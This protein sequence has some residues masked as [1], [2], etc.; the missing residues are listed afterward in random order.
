MA[1]GN[2]WTLEE[3]SLLKT[4]YKTFSSKEIQAFLLER[5][6]SFRSIS[7]IEAK[8]YLLGITKKTQQLKWLDLEIEFLH[9]NYNLLMAKD[10]AKKLDRSTI[11]VN[12]KLKSLGLSKYFVWSSISDKYLKDN[13]QKQS[14]KDISLYLGCT[15]DACLC[16]AF[17]FNLIRA[18]QWSKDETQ[19]L[20]D[21]CKKYDVTVLSSKLDF[22]KKSIYTKLWDLG[23]KDYK[24][25]DS[26]KKFTE[27]EENFIKDNYKKMSLKNICLKLNRTYS[28]ISHYIYSRELNK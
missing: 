17:K 2:L 26:Q 3:V 27:Y 8:A 16:R 22:S 23:I 20:I 12:C 13:Y 14:V 7:S 6:S 1:N 18:K 28:S 10:I 4:S 15:Y 5:C 11:S 25:N 24:K 19:Y 9:K 21:N